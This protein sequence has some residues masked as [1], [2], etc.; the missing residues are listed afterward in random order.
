MRTFITSLLL[1]IA[2]ASFAQTDLPAVPTDSVA[3][4]INLAGERLVKSARRGNWSIGLAVGGALVASG[5]AIIVQQKLASADDPD[6]VDTRPA[7][8]GYIL[9]G[10]MLVGS[11]SLAIDANHYKAKAGRTLRNVRRQ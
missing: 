7:A 1:A 4:R 6:Q 5:T 2:V 10:G 3:F 9:G 8:I 11:I